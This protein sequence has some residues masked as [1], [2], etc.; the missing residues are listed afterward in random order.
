LP[1]IAKLT[2]GQAAYHFISGYTAKVAGTEAGVTE[3]QPN[4]RLVLERHLSLHPTKYAEMLS[5]KMK[6]A[7]VTVWLHPQVDRWSY[8]GGRM[9][10]TQEP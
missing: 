8:G 3:P 1:P 6:D 4:F 9:K 7:N 10:L 5:K 2:P